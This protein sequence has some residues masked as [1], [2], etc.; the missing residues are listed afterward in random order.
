M[1]ILVVEDHADV[2]ETLDDFLA[3]RG[4]RVDLAYDGVRGF[5]LA[6]REDYDAIVLDRMLPGQDGVTLCR[7]L[8]GEAGKATP[9]LMLTALG[10]TADKVQ[11]FDSGA[12]DYLVKPFDLT[13]LEVRLTA[14]HRRSGARVPSARLQVEDLAYDTSALVATRAGRALTLS[15]TGRRILEYLMRHSER[16]VP[17]V[18]LER[19]LWGRDADDP[20]ALRVHIHALRQ[21]IDGESEVKLLQTVRGVGY[22]LAA[23]SDGR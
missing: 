22:R 18:E 3:A 12:D 8:R 5:E 4:H 15:P 1:R 16:V 6:A 2:A 9:V 17:R 21:A 19:H 14:L 7:R 23:P 10:T 13:E 11:G 20:G